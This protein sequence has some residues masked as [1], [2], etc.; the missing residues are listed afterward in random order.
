MRISNVSASSDEIVNELTIS[1][2]PMSDGQG[3]TQTRILTSKFE[4][5]NT[6]R[7]PSDPRLLESLDCK[8]SQATFGLRPEKIELHSVWDSTTAVAI[9][10]HI[11]KK[12]ATPRHSVSYSVPA[13]YWT[14][15]IGDVGLLTDADIYLS[16]RLFIVDGIRVGQSEVELDLV[17]L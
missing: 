12:R 11:L 2:A 16:G 17:L 7:V 10:E 8:T 6:Y 3:F 15:D 14:V 4:K 9:G 13:D 1:Y 5:T